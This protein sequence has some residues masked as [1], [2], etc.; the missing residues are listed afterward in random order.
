VAD[1]QG[2]QERVREK[3]KA[4]YAADPQMAQAQMKMAMNTVQFLASKLPKLPAVALLK[5][6]K[7]TQQQIDKFSRYV[8][9]ATDPQRIITEINSGR[10]VPETVETV[11]ALYPNIFMGVKLDLLDRA[12]EIKDRLTAAKRVQLS[13]LF[14]AP[15]DPTMDP[16]VIGVLSAAHQGKPQE[17]PGPKGGGELKSVPEPTTAQKMSEG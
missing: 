16:N 7:P 14:E 17:K 15:F 4:L 11:K 9:A 13:I 3:L 10:I 5:Q 2:T 1:P 12:H 8:A 6:P